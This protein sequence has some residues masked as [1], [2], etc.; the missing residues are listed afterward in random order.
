M[1]R[2]MIALRPPAWFTDLGSLAVMRAL[3][4]LQ[5]TA[6]LSV[7]DVIDGLQRHG[8][9]E[10]AGGRGGVEA[11]VQASPHLDAARRELDAARARLGP[12][13]DEELVRIARS[14]LAAEGALRPE[15]RRSDRIIV[16][17]SRSCRARRHQRTR[18][19]VPGPPLP[20]SAEG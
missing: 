5:R 19:I 11:L 6:D 18:L 12:V 7:E 20:E 17:G 15:L 14:L 2:V 1:I 13:E 9:L 4:C 8:A 10:L 3:F 16:C